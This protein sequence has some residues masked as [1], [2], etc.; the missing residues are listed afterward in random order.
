MAVIHQEQE[1]NY[2][3]QFKTIKKISVADL[4]CLKQS[5]RDRHHINR[6]L[7]K[8]Q[9]RKRCLYSL[10]QRGRAGHKQYVLT[11]PIF[12]Q[13]YLL[14][15][16]NQCHNDEL[17]SLP[18]FYSFLSYKDISQ[19]LKFRSKMVPTIF[20]RHLQWSQISDSNLIIPD[21]HL[22]ISRVGTIVPTLAG[23]SRE[24]PARGRTA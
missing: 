20:L 12:A 21:N 3:L 9:H 11:D 13:R 5:I 24:A 1:G 4:S 19:F 22:L 17:F 14:A 6:A 18:V 16:S 23:G 7:L 10:S 2:Q 8:S 15:T